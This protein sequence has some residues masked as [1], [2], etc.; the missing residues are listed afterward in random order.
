VDT[1]SVSSLRGMAQA[2]ERLNGVSRRI[3]SGSGVDGP[4]KDHVSLSDDAVA[5]IESSTAVR[6]NAA[7][8][9]TADELANAAM[10]LAR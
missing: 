7:V 4:N 9:P 1:A 10:N 8:E 6:A 2:Q 3:A 5:L